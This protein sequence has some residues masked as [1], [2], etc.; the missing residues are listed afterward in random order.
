MGSLGATQDY[1]ESR[2]PIKS[3]L[4]RLAYACPPRA[5]NEMT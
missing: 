4:A 1:T 3:W 5:S 2:A